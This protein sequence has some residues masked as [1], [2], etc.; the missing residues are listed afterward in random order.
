M[1]SCWA[2]S[3]RPGCDYGLGAFH[4]PGVKSCR[5]V[6]AQY[7]DAESE[8]GYHERLRGMRR[9]RGGQGGG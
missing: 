2:E 3:Q 6:V 1:Y 5:Y 8:K 9:A 7:L 4:D